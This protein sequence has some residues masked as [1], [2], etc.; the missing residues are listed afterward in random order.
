MNQSF[1]NFF[2]NN[3]NA[4]F[5]WFIILAV[6]AL[7]MN[8]NVKGSIIAAVVVLVGFA[9]H[10]FAASLVWIGLIPFIGPIIAHVL[11]LPFIWILN[12]IG[13][14]VSLVA[15]KRGYSKDVLSYRGLTVALLTGITIGFILGK[16]L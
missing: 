6:V 4:I 8:F 14:L 7:G 2:S 11:A 5:S 15:I 12:G 13:Y 1:K 3:E 9:G 16:L 10:A